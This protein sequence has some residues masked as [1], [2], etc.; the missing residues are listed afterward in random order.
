MCACELLI[1]S[2]RFGD[3]MENLDCVLIFPPISVDERYSKSV[4]RVG[5]HLPPLGLAYIA[6]NLMHNGFSVK[7]IDGPA[8]CLG[9]Q[10]LIKKVIDADPKVIFFSSLT[11]TFDRA[12]F[13]AAEIKKHLTGVPIII[14]G[15]HATIMKEKIFEN[16]TPFDAV[17]IGEGET[18]SL[19]LMQHYTKKSQA[20]LEDING[21]A[22][23]KGGIVVKTKDREHIKNLDILPYPARELLDMRNYQPLP[24]Q[25]L[26]LPV[27]HMVAIRG[28]PYQ[29]TYCSNSP[30]FGRVIRLRSPSNVVNEMKHVM[31]VHGAKEIAFWDDMLTMKKE[32]I[33]ELCDRI[34]KY[35]LDIVWSCYA[36]VNTVDREMLKKMKSAGCWNIFYGLESGNQELL[37]NIKKGITLEQIRNAILWTK[38]AGIETRGSFMLGLP[39]ETPELARKTID[40]AISLDL[41]YVQFCITTPYPGTELYCNADKYGRLDK[42]LSRYTTWQPVFVPYG[43]KDESELKDMSREAFRKFYLRPKYVL[44]RIKKIRSFED[45][46]RNLKGLRLIF[47]FIDK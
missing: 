4:G 34:I 20:K 25:Y 12:S 29:C 47:G 45:V 10:E 16:D 3:C 9:I 6:G 40:F 43:Y 11:S 35:K 38:E 31:N 46:F 1:V 39:G 19:E 42:T 28:C 17:V 32:W 24:N 18:T 2:L 33:N 15:I 30:I 44:K 26:R 21:I 22:F 27:V 13:A 23:K 41:D 8:E 14:G 37:D 7:I 36:R 5:G